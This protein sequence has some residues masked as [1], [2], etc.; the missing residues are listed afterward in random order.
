MSKT[1]PLGR[2][3]KGDDETRE[4]T[5]QIEQEKGEVGSKK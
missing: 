2:K 3:Q 5:G 4:E 1:E